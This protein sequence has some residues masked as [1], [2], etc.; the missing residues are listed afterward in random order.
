MSS[1]FLN[2][3][4]P[5][6]T[7]AQERLRVALLALSATGQPFPQTLATLE[8]LL[9]RGVRGQLERIITPTLALEMNVARLRG[10]LRGQTPEQRFDDYIGLLGRENYRAAVAAEYPVLFQLAAARLD[11]WVTVSLEWLSRLVNDWPEIKETF[12]SNGE[13]GELIELRF[14]QRNTKRGGRSVVVMAFTSGANLVYKPRSLAVDFRFQAL[15]AWL[16][17]A[18][19]D[20][21]FRAIRMI[22]SGTHGWMEWID[23]AGCADEAGLRRFYRRQGAY[24]ALFYSLEATDIHMSN[25]IAAGEHPALIDLEALFHP[26]EPTPDWPPLELALDELAH[27]SVLR[28]GLLPEPEKGDDVELEPL[29]LSG[30]AGAGGQLTPYLVPAWQGRKTDTLHRSRE[31]ETIKGS[32][33][34]PTLDGRPVNPAIFLD[35]VDEG[36]AAAYRLLANHKDELLADDGLLAT[37]SASEIRVLPRSGRNYGDILENG[38]HPD[39]L[40]QPDARRHYFE[41]RLREEGCDQPELNRLVPHEA[42]ALLAGDGPL[43]FTRAGSLDLFTRQGAW[44][45]AYF[46]RSGLEMARQRVAALNEDDLARQRWLIRASF[47]TLAPPGPVTIQRSIAL[48]QAAAPDLREQALDAARAIG[49]RLARS[50]VCVA[51]E[52]SWIGLE[53]DEVDHWFIEPLGDDLAY[54]LPGVALFLAHLAGQTGD[55]H[56]RD[57]AVAAVATTLRYAAEDRDE[58]DEADEAGA[59]PAGLVFGWGGRLYALSQLTALGIHPDLPEEIGLL[60]REARPQLQNNI[61][62]NDPGLAYGLVGGL[63]GLLAAHHVMPGSNALEAAR[64]AGDRLLSTLSDT[65]EPVPVELFATFNYGAAGS[66]GSLFALAALTGEKRFLDAAHK[67]ANEFATGDHTDPGLWRAYLLAR[68]WLPKTGRKRLDGVL[69]QALPGAVAQVF[70]RT[71]SLEY[72]DLGLIDLLLSAAAALEDVGLGELAGRYATTVIDDI[73]GDGARTAIPLGIESP[74]FAAG[75]AGIGYGLLRVA[76]PETTPPLPTL[77]HLVEVN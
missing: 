50:A 63:L 24:L 61:D 5:Q 14:P 12:F 47:A 38:Y 59:D 32:K 62:D 43:F 65:P 2:V 31:R 26:R 35:D 39:L 7:R 21:P 1:G 6:I 77:A 37:F 22:D 28:P 46:P 74:G 64:L 30:L 42:A 76:A 45:R 20:P 69:R 54:G 10:D 44:L 71:H 34:L 9:F 25:I 66:A 11:M 75:L 55:P 51:G 40:R 72:G 58:E 33:N 23:P 8:S 4:A 19:F 57:L 13:P 68:P 3:L 36:F 41:K 15:L 60:V 73:R 29:D 17:R 56:W 52:A 18:G 49:D 53:P 48:P 27:Y 16:N 70:G 67:L